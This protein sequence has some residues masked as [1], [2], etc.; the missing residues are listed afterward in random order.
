MTS[1]SVGV[2]IWAKTVF[3][4]AFLFGITLLFKADIMGF[5]IGIILLFGGFIVSMPLLLAVVPL[6]NISTRLPYRIPARIAWLTFYLIVL[7]ILFFMLLSSLTRES[8]FSASILK[9][10]MWLSILSVLVAVITTR[11]SLY[12]LNTYTDELF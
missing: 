12:K 5:F 1:F 11:K 8:D 9:L 10:L 7:I 4:N 2:K 6:I 3:L